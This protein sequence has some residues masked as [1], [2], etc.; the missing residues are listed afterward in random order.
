MALS[1]LDRAKRKFAQEKYGEVIKLLEPCV[2]D[3]HESF[4]FHLYLGLACL[5]EGIVT[6]AVSYLGRARQIKMSHPT[7]LC[8]EAALALKRRDTNRA[9]ERYIA[10]LDADP[11]HRLAQKGL[12]ALKAHHTPESLAGFIQSGKVK[13]LY[14]R[15]GVA[16]Y[17]RRSVVCAVGVGCL[18]TLLVGAL[19]IAGLRVWHSGL[20]R[21]TARTSRADVSF[22]TLT[23][24]EYARPLEGSGSYRYT[25][26]KQ[27]VLQ[28]YANAQKYFQTFKDNA[29]QVEINKLLA[30]NASHSIKRRA[31]MLMDYFALPTFDTFPDEDNYPYV[32]VREQKGLYLD[33]WVVWQG[34]AANVKRTERSVS[35]NLLVGYDRL[36]KLE[37]IVPVFCNFVVSVDPQKPIRVLGKVQMRGDI[38]YLKARSVFQSVHSQSGTVSG[39][40]QG[41][42]AVLK[43]G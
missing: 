24:E 9:V 35:F 18:C 13:A 21:G 3:Y 6:V 1:V 16:E 28:S 30:S 42:A 4:V 25:L 23:K 10:V 37:G 29:A 2:L 8:A 41:A 22:L 39:D 14:P 26:S 5:H 27:D 40:R 36:T 43:A 12:N 38:L 34:M 31:R 7:L 32:Q 11:K 20:W 19:G 15:P 33:C 17:R